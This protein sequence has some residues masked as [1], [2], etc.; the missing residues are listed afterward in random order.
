MLVFGFLPSLKTGRNSELLEIFIIIIILHY[1]I[2]QFSR[3]NPG[4]EAEV[5]DGHLSSNLLRIKVKH[6][7]HRRWSVWKLKKRHKL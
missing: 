2:Q 7:Q 3:F 6:T 5:D 1:L 4:K